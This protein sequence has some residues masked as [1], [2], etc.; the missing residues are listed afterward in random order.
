MSSNPRDISPEPDEVAELRARLLTEER[1]LARIQE[2]GTALGSTLD[3]DRLLSLIMDRVT[4]L[5]DA[6]R[7]TLYLLSDDGQELWSKVAQGGEIR[8]IRLRVG[9]GIAGWVAQSGQVVN[10]P[11][12]YADPRFQQ[13]FDRRSGYRTRSILCM[14]MRNNLGRILGVVQVLNKND[15]G[16]FSRE[17]EALL[18]TVGGQAA[19]S[20]ENS[21][22][23]LSVVGK[24]VQLLET[25]EKL[26]QK[27]YEL[28]LL[29]EIE[30]EMHG[31]VDLDEMLD[32]LLV[33]AMDLVGTEAGSILLREQRTDELYFRSA[34]G[35]KGDSVRRLRIPMAEGIVG[36][37][38]STKQPLI[39]N[40]PAADARFNMKFAQRIGFMPRN[41]LCVP[42]LA[43]GNTLGAFELL[44]KMGARRFDAAELKLLTLIAGQAS[45]AIQ[46][47]R[48][49][50]EKLNQSRLASIGQ[51][52][53]GVLHD[54]KTPMTIV[55]GYAQLMA[56]I[57]DG[58][59]RSQYV[60][61][62]LKQF[63]LMNAMAREVL[64]FARGESNVLIR[65][66]YLHKFIEE[67]EAHLAQE[68]AG[69]NVEFVMQPLYKGAAFFDEAK[70]LRVIHNIAR[71]AAQAMAPQGGG[72]FTLCVST[73]GGKLLFT[74]ADT[75]PGIPP[76]IEGRLFELFATSGKK[77]GTGLGLAIVKKIVDEHKGDITYHTKAGHGTTFVISL[78]LERAAGD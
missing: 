4:E 67:I 31:A 23:Y 38:A 76:E 44:N 52:L 12:A 25:Q 34:R 78:P 39:V 2:I 10:I 9:E 64:Q 54:L 63:D 53:S 68:F 47:A 36:W 24:N 77:D 69:K 19:I 26:E 21:K 20:I 71:N 61:Q 1:R 58:R 30:E 35:E 32:K 57:D 5:L 33:R 48:A 3:L 16:P 62:I 75:G 14:P 66:V 7:S 29:F 50:E 42:L 74:F 37:V 43:E 46:L 56:Q 15:G 49:K 65:K 6:D 72:T 55:S 8:E 59:Q 45:K 13:E 28:D 41:I 73:L 17:D 27:M 51:M 18:H 40:D 22:L 60:D 70:L 11:D